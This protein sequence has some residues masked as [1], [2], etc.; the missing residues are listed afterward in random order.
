MEE[1]INHY[2]P[3]LPL[4]LPSSTMKPTCPSATKSATSRWMS[5]STSKTM[6]SPS[7]I[8][9]GQVFV[10]A[11]PPSLPSFFPSRLSQAAVTSEDVVNAN[12]VPDTPSYCGPSFMAQRRQSALRPTNSPARTQDLL[13]PFSPPFSVYPHCLPPQTTG[14]SLSLLSLTS[15]Y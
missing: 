14:L 8:F 12:H 4:P 10:R 7:S 2:L 6:A 15:L 9:T 5:T 11:Y 13:R 1:D 3:P